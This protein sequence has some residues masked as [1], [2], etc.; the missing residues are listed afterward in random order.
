MNGK[1]FLERMTRQIPAGRV[2]LPV[3]LALLLPMVAGA[4]VWDDCLSWVSAE[5][6]NGDGKFNNGEL[7]DIRHAGVADSPTHGGYLFHSDADHDT[8]EI[9]TKEVKF[10][11]H[12]N[13]SLNCP[14]LY[15]KAPSAQSNVTWSALSPQRV[16]GNIIS[17]ACPI[18]SDNTYSVLLRFAPNL[19]HAHNDSYEIIMELGWNNDNPTTKGLLLAL[20][21]GQSTLR[22]GGV[23]GGPFK[24]SG[25]WLGNQKN[26]WHEV[27]VLVD[28]AHSTV[29][30][31]IVT[32]GQMAQYVN[33][34]TTTKMN[35]AI[36]NWKTLDLGANASW[37]T[38]NPEKGLLLGGDGTG[39]EKTMY[40]GQIHMVALWD[41]VLT[42]N[43]V[44][45]AFTSCPS[46][47]QVGIPNVNGTDVFAGASDRAVEMTPM[48]HEWRKFPA[49]L[50]AGNPV[51]ISFA[52]NG[53]HL[54]NGLPQLLR[55]VPRAGTAGAVSV[56]INGTAC[57]T[58]SLSSG[59]DACIYVPVSRLQSGTNVCTITRVDGG[60]GA[61][62]LNAVQ[63][64]GSWNVG[65]HSSNADSMESAGN[66][67]TDFYIEGVRRF[68]WFRR[69]ITPARPLN[70]HLGDLLGRWGNNRWIY[71]CRIAE[72]QGM[73][74]GENKAVVKLNG[75]TILNSTPLANGQ[76]FTFEL[77][78]TNLIRGA[79]NVIT[80]EN[81]GGTTYYAFDYHDWE[82][83]K[84]RSGLYIIFK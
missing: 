14:V 66:T 26:A 10:P 34:D 3:V 73:G 27:A 45:E 41:R 29:S 81:D 35:K 69:A 17:N 33:G 70:I 22:I 47:F 40:R 74:S 32:T 57:G 19:A 2:V 43:E 52:C 39:A 65:W 25:L 79:D 37:P 49:S 67:E 28:G 77:S 84:R 56:A 1:S 54:G 21:T 42:T 36:M 46:V 72:G 13:R 8:V 55:L 11:L 12:N 59:K 9:E 23:P 50:T 15:F 53:L 61:L 83:Q 64:A 71:T 24:D 75:T 5:D 31:G 82:V 4:G 38:P 80:W 62:G 48:P 60:S 68:E 44:L 18:P 20:H 51:N 76:T 6:K 78:S 58:V 7:V 16:Y 63:L 30:V